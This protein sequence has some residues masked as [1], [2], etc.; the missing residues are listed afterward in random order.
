[1]W[2]FTRSRSSTSRRDGHWPSAWATR[3]A[4]AR[5]HPDRRGPHSFAGV[6]FFLDLAAIRGGE[7]VLDLGSGSGMD[8][9][10]AAR[11][12]GPTGRV[13]GIDMTEEQLDKATGLAAEAGVEHAA[14]RPGYIERLPVADSSTDVMISNGVINL[15]PN[16]RAVFGEAARVLRPGGRLALADIVTDSEL[17]EGVCYLRCIPVGGLHRRRCTGRRL[18]GGD[19]QRRLHNRGRTGQSPAPLPVRKG[20]Q[21]RPP[22]SGA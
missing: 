6:G 22:R 19:H 3:L 13:I 14:F 2:R 20:R 16:K 5:R 8:S 15:S 11:K 18:P 7:I 12:V 4:R 1:M 10:L 17:P 9:L 21:S